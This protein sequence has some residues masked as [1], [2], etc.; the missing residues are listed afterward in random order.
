LAILVTAAIASLALAAS[1]SAIPSSVTID[2]VFK[3][4]GGFDG[5]VSSPNANCVD[6]RKVVVFRKRPGDDRKLGGDRTDDMGDW[7]VATQLRDGRYYARVKPKE[8]GNRTCRGARSA[9][10]ALDN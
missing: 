8:I 4:T 5:E 1:A 3:G 10:L 6:D 7:F 9:T 2:T